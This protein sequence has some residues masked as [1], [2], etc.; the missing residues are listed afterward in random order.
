MNND[1]RETMSD[2][3]EVTTEETT[4][5]ETTTDSTELEEKEDIFSNYKIPIVHKLPKRE[6][7]IPGHTEQSISSNIEIYQSKYE[8][9][10]LKKFRGKKVLAFAGIGNPKNFFKLL[11]DNGLKISEEIS[12][13][14]H[15]NYKKNEIE[16]LILQAKEKGLKLIT[17]EK[18]YFRIKD[19]GFK[20]IKFLK[21]KLEISEK[22]KLI[23]LILN[24]S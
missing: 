20:N 2:S 3:T 8:L 9:N 4:T 23:N 19:Y 21:I 16:N 6:E 17:T 5:E 15:Y 18:D 14:D 24:Q 7:S 10:N 1:I 22:D 12:F 13:P 11:K